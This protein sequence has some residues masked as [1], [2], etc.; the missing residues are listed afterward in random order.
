MDLSLNLKAIVSQ[1][2]I[3]VK[4]GK[5]R[6]AAVEVL[7]NS[8]LVSDLI[9]K[10][11]MHEIKEVMKKSKELGMKTFDM[12]L[13]DLYEEDRIS[14]EDALRFADSMNEV[15]LQIKLHGKEMASKDLNAGIQNLD[16]V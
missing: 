7:L 4:E 6:A 16:I 3:P 10:G 8:P 11:N 2:L 13:F 14:Y 15:R 5:G 1:R 9:H 12:A